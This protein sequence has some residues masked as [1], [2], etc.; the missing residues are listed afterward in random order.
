MRRAWLFLTLFLG[1]PSCTCSGGDDRV[2]RELQELRGDVRALTQTMVGLMDEKRSSEERIKSLE[3][4]LKAQAPPE[5]VGG[6]P[7]AARMSDSPEP[8]EEIEAPQAPP[9]R[10]ER[11]SGE[12]SLFSA[13]AEQIE[14]IRQCNETF[15][16]GYSESDFQSAQKSAPE[17]NSRLDR[18]AALLPTPADSEEEVFWKLWN[19]LEEREDLWRWEK[20]SF[21]QVSFG[22][23]FTRG[24]DWVILDLESHRGL[25]PKDVD[26]DGS[27]TIQLIAAALI[28]PGWL[29]A[30][31]G[32]NVPFVW[33][34]GRTLD[35][36]P[37]TTLR[38]YK[39]SNGWIQLAG[40]YF[41]KADKRFAIP[42]LI[43]NPAN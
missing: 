41:G 4:Q 30:M 29:R 10:R 32:K 40:E 7:D 9:V 28:H 36:P 18:A 33:I 11:P 20:V 38:L 5:P 19:C 22:E 43:G 37:E 12:A 24:L 35:D 39:K 42:T 16:W 14:I 3:D 8:P 26:R 13:P 17:G 25:A 21:S 15:K 31:D 2:V 6:V 34:A 23:R 1:V 27:P